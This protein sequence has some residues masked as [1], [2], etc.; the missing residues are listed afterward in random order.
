VNGIIKPTGHII[1]AL[2]ENK[3]HETVKLKWENV[4]KHE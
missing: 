4:Y 2:G 1:T 3:L